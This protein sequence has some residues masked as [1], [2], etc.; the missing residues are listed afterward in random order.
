MNKDNSKALQE[1][2]FITKYAQKK[3]D[4]TKETWDDAVDRIWDMHEL[5]YLT[6][7]PQTEEFR[8]GELDTLM[9]IARQAE[10]DKIFLSAQRLRQFASTDASTGIW[11]HNFK[12]YNCSATYADR[13]EFF[14]ELMYVLLTG[15][16]AGV[17]VQ[18]V[19]INKLPVVLPNIPRISRP[20]GLFHEVEDSIEGW[21]DAVKRLTASY[22]NG[23]HYITFDYSKIRPKGSLIA[24]QFLA[25]GPEGLKN[26]LDKLRI[27]LDGAVGRQLR[28]IEVYDMVMWIADAVL[29]G[30]V[31]RSAV[32]I[33]FDAFDESMMN[34][35]TGEW[36]VEN[37]QRALSNNSAVLIRSKAERGH[38][39]RLMNSTKEFGEPGFLFLEDE[40]VVLN[41]CAEISMIP[42][43][44]DGRSGWAVCNLTEINGGLVDSLDKL[45]FAAK[46]AT[47]AGT[48]QAGY[49]LF[50]YLGEVTEEIIRR[51]ALIGVS[52]TG[53]MENP[54]ILFN[55]NNL[56]EAAELVIRWNHVVAD[57]IGINYAK[58]TTTTKPSGNA[59]IL[60]GTTSGIHGDHSE[61]YIRNVQA[62]KAEIGQFIYTTKNP[63]A[64]E[65]SAVNSTDVIISFAMKA[66]PESIWKKDLLG[67]KQLEYVKIAQQNWVEYGTFSDSTF[68]ISLRHNISNTIQVTRDSWDDVSNY[69]WDN[70]HVFSGV[71]LLNSGG[72]LDYT[73]SPFQAVKKPIELAELYG[74]AA[75]LA[76][77]LITEVPVGF[78]S[79]WDACDAVK[80]NKDFKTKVADD[81]GKKLKLNMQSDWVRRV[82][83]FAKNFLKNDVEKAIYCLKDVHLLHR[84]NKL[85]NEST[86]VDWSEI[87]FSKDAY[88]MA[89]QIEAACSGGNCETL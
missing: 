44:E 82:R 2:N 88:Q 52:I 74:S 78:K 16:G 53:W 3:A 12:A 46:Q 27:I 17:S 13:P 41:P 31:R 86:E 1:Y 28:S 72:D 71:S 36:W 50:P 59:S 29:S 60:L 43:L 79:L 76:S 33:Q 81:L 42:R 4:G 67:I 25:P 5:R 84:W 14:G 19:H 7:T 54:T 22:F 57:I 85:K 77:G 6:L 68:G 39:D 24:G 49:T 47:I 64:V 37:P 35:K 21:G 32:L 75:I 48:L 15:A 8:L 66:K 38:F 87:D 63:F 89:S 23:T 18:H 30:G 40:D 83:K 70:R 56:K 58:R 55:E 73:Q 45:L 9:Q 51:D 20:D 65:D 69:I 62:N 26:T 34:A 10:K 61:R 11:K 80:F